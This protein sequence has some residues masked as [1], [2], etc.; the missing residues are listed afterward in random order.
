[1]S[2]LIMNKIIFL[3]LLTFLATLSS[4][5]STNDVTNNQP[6]VLQNNSHHPDHIV[7]IDN[8]RNYKCKN[9]ITKNKDVAKISNDSFLTSKIKNLNQ[10]LRGKKA[11]FTHRSGAKIKL[12]SF[13]D[14]KSINLIKEF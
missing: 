6:C 7:A 5:N 10:L 3:I 14:N 8:L 13:G 1:M 4:A 9:S 11:V 12:D 2:H